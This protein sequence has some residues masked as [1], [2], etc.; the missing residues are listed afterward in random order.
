MAVSGGGCVAARIHRMVD[1]AAP[2][3]P[4]QGRKIPYARQSINRADIEAVVAHHPETVVYPDA[5][6]GFMREGEMAE[7]SEANKK[8]RQD[9][10]TRWKA[11]RGLADLGIEPSRAA[12]VALAHDPDFRV[13]LETA[14]ALAGENVS[15]DRTSK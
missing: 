13:R 2:R 6:H 3:A 15:I 1:D 8:A 5:T 11:L 7:G 4:A 10:W 9:A 12:V 14:R